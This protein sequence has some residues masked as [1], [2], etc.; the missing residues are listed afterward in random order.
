MIAL[1]SD[2]LCKALWGAQAR[3]VAKGLGTAMAHHSQE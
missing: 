1:L 3:R 2:L